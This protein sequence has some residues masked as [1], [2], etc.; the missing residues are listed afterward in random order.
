MNVD[1]FVLRKKCEL[2]HRTMGMRSG[3]EERS[4]SV[5]C[6]HGYPG[7]LLPGA[8]VQKGPSLMPPVYSLLQAG[9]SF[10]MWNDHAN[11]LVN[12]W[13]RL[14][15]LGKEKLWKS[16]F[17]SSKTE[18]N[19]S[20]GRILRKI[21]FF[22]PQFL[23]LYYGGKMCLPH[24]GAMR[25]KWVESYRVLQKPSVAHNKHPVSVHTGERA[26]RLAINVSVVASMWELIQNM[27][28]GKPFY[29]TNPIWVP[30]AHTYNPSYLGGWTREDHDLK[31]AQAKS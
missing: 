14:D 23:P 11:C 18:P 5:F 2:F 27:L 6:E 20:N 15:H 12:K 30:V 19:P 31:P 21:C 24:G 17:S 4:E 26:K 3:T 22:L 25:N 1:A 8:E 10:I 16:L 28:P 9:L 29:R 13:F 7:H